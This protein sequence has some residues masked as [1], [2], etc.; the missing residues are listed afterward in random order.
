M[1]GPDD[2]LVRVTAAGICHSDA[3]YF[4]G[5]PRLPPLPRTL[6]H[7]IAGVV[8]AVGEAV[9]AFAPGDPVGVHYQISC[10]ECSYCRNG[11]DQFCVRGS[12]IGNHVDGGYAELVHVPARNLVKVPAGVDAKVAAVTMCSTATVFHAFRK[13]R[14]APGESVAVFGL[15]GLGQS[16]VRI[17]KAMGAGTVFG[18]DLASSKLTLA[19]KH[20]A[21]PIAGGDSAPAA[22]TEA[23]GA[24]IALEL[25]G[26]NVTMRQA[27]EVL[28]PFGRAMAVGLTSAA[29]GF[30]AYDDLVVKEAE[31]IGVSD[32][33]R[34]ELPEVLQLIADGLLDLSDVVTSTVALDAGQVTSVLEQLGSFGEAVRTVITPGA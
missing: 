11:H 9:D 6:G 21:V 17:A 23:G 2:A 31:I 28:R 14:L 22:I 10:G 8:E 18:V 25:V 26:S 33:L 30:N 19:D 13:A 32:H 29:T 1:L 3:H 7:E 20:G 34:S 24:D 12:M 4:E 16:A 27:I 15:G 5:V